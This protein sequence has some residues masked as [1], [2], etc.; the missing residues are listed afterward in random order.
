MD[1]LNIKKKEQELARLQRTISRD[2]EKER[3]E[4]THKLIQKGAMLESYFD[5]KDMNID[6]TEKFLKMV[7]PYIKKIRDQNI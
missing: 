6:E 4:R 3:K 7:A 2:K 5:M 1:K